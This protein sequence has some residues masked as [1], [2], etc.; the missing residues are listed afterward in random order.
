MMKI[1]MKERTSTFKCP[2][3]VTCHSPSPLEDS[4]TSGKRG[5]VRRWEKKKGIA[6]TGVK[7]VLVQKLHASSYNQAS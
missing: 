1:I 3:N 4:K 6:Y 2:Y 7:K 5:C